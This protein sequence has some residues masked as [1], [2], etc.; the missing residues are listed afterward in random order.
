MCTPRG[1][2]VACHPRGAAQ[3]WSPARFAAPSRGSRIRR[4]NIAGAEP[5]R[6]PNVVP[7]GAESD[8]VVALGR[9]VV[10]AEILGGDGMLDPV[11]RWH[12]VAS[13]QALEEAVGE[14]GEPGPPQIQR[15]VVLG[16]DVAVWRDGEGAWRAVED[17]C[18]HRRAALSLGT[19]RPD[20]TL[21]CRFHGWC[22]NGR[23]ECTH[24]PQTPEVASRFGSGSKIA[25]FPT[26]EKHGLLWVWPD[27]SPSSWIDS[28]AHM[29]AVHKATDPDSD[30]AAPELPTDYL[31]AVDNALHGSGSKSTADGQASLGPTRLSNDAQP[32]AN[33][34]QT[35][36]AS[37]DKGLAQSNGVSQGDSA[38]GRAATELKPPVT[39]AASVPMGGSIANRHAPVHQAHTRLIFGKSV[40][41]SAP[42][43]QVSGVGSEDGMATLRA[44]VEAVEAVWGFFNALPLLLL[45]GYVR[46]SIEHLRGEGELPELPVEQ[47]VAT[48][49]AVKILGSRESINWRRYPIVPPP[50][51][52]DVPTSPSWLNRFAGGEPTWIGQGHAQGPHLRSMHSRWES[53]TKSCHACRKSLKYLRALETWLL[54]AV[55]VFLAATLLAATLRSCGSQWKLGLWVGAGAAIWGFAEVQNLRCRLLHESRGSDVTENDRRFRF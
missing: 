9:D 44:V 34:V 39:V 29:P 33:F 50:S 28:A 35:G 16:M 21:A 30:S 53:H 26:L 7:E 3:L 22:F 55:A 1:S 38:N 48:P 5:R 54:K 47:G 8:A 19:V 20:G 42:A 2:A 24:A 27:D 40:D 18:A 10:R 46:T 37:A 43:G 52:H 51:G 32:L 36:D 31:T 41:S 12:P 45:P 15:R 23:G 6:R 17:R 11:R 14:E 49:G 13:L 4:A 25:A